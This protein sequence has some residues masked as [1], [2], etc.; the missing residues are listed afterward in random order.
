[1]KCLE[2]GFAPHEF[3]LQMFTLHCLHAWEVTNIAGCRCCHHS[4]FSVY[5]GSQEHLVFSLQ[6]QDELASVTCTKLFQSILFLC[7]MNMCSM[8]V[9]MSGVA[10]ACELKLAQACTS[11]VLAMFTKAAF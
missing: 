9:C 6:S 10:Q 2:L 11:S 5:S 8:S 1:M 7:K 3:S 4:S